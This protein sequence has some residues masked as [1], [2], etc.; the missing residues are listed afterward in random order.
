MGMQFVT[1]PAA[2]A[3]D[4]PLD[5]PG[6]EVWRDADGRLAAVGYRSPQGHALFVP[7]IGTFRFDTAPETIVLEPLPAVDDDLIDD[8]FHRIALPLSVQ[9]GGVQVLHASAVRCGNGVAAL[10]GRAGAGKSTLA[11]ALSRRG[12]QLC[13][14]DAVPFDLSGEPITVPPLPFRM[15][16]RP[17]SAEWFEAPELLKGARATPWQRTGGAPFSA[18]FVLERPADAAPG[19]LAVDRLAPSDAFGAILPH[20][21]YVVLDDEAANRRLVSAYLELADRL[22]VFAV[23]YHPDLAAVDRIAAAIEKEVMS[24]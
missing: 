22:P 7:G 2:E 13:A 24:L 9:F 10:C 6:T 12:H 1:L 21:Y 8:A 18:L 4:P 14:D 17:A 19:D 3:V 16:L 20:A 15:R 23:R 11:F 5:G